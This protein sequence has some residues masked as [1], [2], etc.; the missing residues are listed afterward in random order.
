MY[1]CREPLPVDYRPGSIVKFIRLTEILDYYDGIQIF[2]GQDANGGCYVGS[3]IDQAGP[4]DRYLVTAAAPESLQQFREGHLDL[5][6]LLL[7]APGGQWYLSLDQE[8]GDA[9]LPLTPQSGPLAA[10]DYLPEPGLF[11]DCAANP[12]LPGTG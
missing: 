5:R 8:G 7:S 6:T 11:L 12:A 1:N 9:P 10:T 4:A 2:A 3:L